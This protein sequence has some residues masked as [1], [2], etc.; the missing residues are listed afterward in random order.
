MRKNLVN[1]QQPF[2]QRSDTPMHQA[3]I[4]N[5]AP[6]TN[7]PGSTTAIGNNGATRVESFADKNPNAYNQ[8]CA[9][10]DNPFGPIGKNFGTG[11]TNLTEFKTN[12]N[13]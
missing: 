13:T 11:K 3:T 6:V 7:R 2:G 9:G 10:R 12:S 8:A 4:G 5:K 1:E